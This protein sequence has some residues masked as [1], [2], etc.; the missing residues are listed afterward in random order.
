MFVAVTLLLAPTFVIFQLLLNYFTPGL[1]RI[2]GPF[3]ARFS[4]LWR[5]IDACRGHRE[6]TILGLHKKYGPVVRIGPNCITIADPA[7]IDLILGLKTNLDKS[8]HVKPM[9][10]P[11]EGEVLPML[12]SAIDSKVHA[13][14][15]RP[16]A[17]A[18][19]LSNIL[20]YEDVVNNAINKLLRRLREEFEGKGA[21][22][23]CSI[24][25]W[26]NMFSFDLIGKTTFGKEFGLVDAG[27][28]VNDMMHTLDLQFVYIGVVGFMPWIDYLLL[29]NP[30]LLALVKTPNYLV[31]FTS[32]RIRNRRSGEEKGDLE[33]PD[34]LSKFLDAQKLHPDVVSDLQVSAYASTNV[35]AASDTTGAA[36]TAI[37][38]HV[39]KYPAV[40]RKLQDEL[41][42]SDLT[43]PVSYSKAQ[44]L[45]YLDAIVKETL[46]YCPTIA[47]DLERKVGPSGLVLPTG[48]ILP[49]G[50]IV[51]INQW[52][53]H[54]NTSI[55]GDDA[56][57]YK[58]E[59]WLQQA[60]ESVAEYEER[61]RAMQRCFIEFGHGPRAC[62]GK[63][64]ALMEIYKLIPTL[65]GLFDVRLH[66]KASKTR[67][68]LCVQL[69][70]SFR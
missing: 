54:R 7:A 37:I 26:V 42:G 69:L 19:S 52:P 10:N 36:L 12:I 58:P 64:L 18:F 13:R 65:F 21:G 25:K 3:L 68:F 70:T 24:D 41:D 14:I 8:D 61:H 9:Q 22:R 32:E 45:P 66:S 1:G 4:D 28:D 46:R 20:G 49:S 29:K 53:I 30:L 57:V 5:F 6:Q 15:K 39:L 59:R 67:D 17:G 11:V 27:K 43:Y 51:G 47:V 62:I 31:Q 56:D 2:P 23:P 48:E 35:L 34:F 40:L 16:I 50:T 33:K 38:T 44:L 60:N 63:H 55:F